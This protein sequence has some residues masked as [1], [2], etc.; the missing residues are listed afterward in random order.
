MVVAGMRRV[1][2]IEKLVRAKCALFDFDGV[3]ADTE[4]LY[5]E[6]DRRALAVFGYEATDEELE[7]FVGKASEV[8]GPA[9]LVQH[10]IQ[11]TEED[12]L[13]VWDS[14]RD[15]YG[16]PGLAPNPGLPELWACLRKRGCR[17]AVVSTTR[18]A[19][20]VRALNNFG[21]LTYVDAIVGREMV[22]R[23]KPDPEPYLRALEILGADAADAVAFDDSSSGVAS[24]RAAGVYTVCYRGDSAADARL[25]DF[26]DLL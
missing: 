15:I 24:A 12:Y 25:T 22:S 3:V 6:L 17:I 14:D 4:P 19:S 9:L 23:M 26:R 11:A 13:A 2:L 1:P 16:N 10:G 18:C 21:M 7:G 5:V 8:E 20:L